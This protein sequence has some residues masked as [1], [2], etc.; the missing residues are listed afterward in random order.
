MFASLPV[1]MYKQSERQ[2]ERFPCKSRDQANT[3][4]LRTTPNFIYLAQCV[5]QLMEG[6]GPV[7][8]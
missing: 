2:I 1:H 8:E 7:W 3:C 4:L 5:N 6:V